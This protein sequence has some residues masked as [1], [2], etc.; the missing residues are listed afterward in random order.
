MPAIIYI[1]DKYHADFE[2]AML[3]AVNNTWDNDTVAAVVGA[4]LGAL[5]G[6]QAIPKKWIKGL[7]GKLT[8]EGKNGQVFDLI[9]Q[10]KVKWWD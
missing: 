4:V 7:S 3:E 6:K 8:D 5:H 2:R 10:S 9:A 1:L